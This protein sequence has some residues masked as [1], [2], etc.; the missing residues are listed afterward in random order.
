MGNK[1]SPP[2]HCHVT[3]HFNLAANKSFVLSK[4]SLTWVPFGDEGDGDC[5]LLLTGDFSSED[6]YKPDAD[7]EDG[8]LSEEGT[9]S[10][11]W[12]EVLGRM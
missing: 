6:W 4:L 11:V 2:S 7:P 5:G 8:E 1:S 10:C 12:P 9:L 3:K